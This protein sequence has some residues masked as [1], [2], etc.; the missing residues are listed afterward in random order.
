MYGPLHF[1]IVSNTI[2]K[3]VIVI[4]EQVFPGLPGPRPSI[5]LEE[6]IFVRPSIPERTVPPAEAEAPP[7][8]AEAPRTRTFFP[9][10]WQF[11]VNQ[12]K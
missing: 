12:T 5:D 11:V 6:N 10:T 4:Y 9:E 1:Q 7:A 3:F 2:L 8:E